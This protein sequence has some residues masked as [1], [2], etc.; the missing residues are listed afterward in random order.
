MRV[1]QV[2]TYI[3][4]DGAFGGPVAVAIAQ[5]VELA[6]RGHEVDLYA[7]WDGVAAVEAPGVTLRLFRTKDRRRGLSLT[8]VTSIR[9]LLDLRRRR[10]YYDVFHLHFG[11][12]AVSMS[13]W[14]VLHRR[15]AKAVLQTHGM[16]V[17]DDRIAVRLV[18]WL[19]VIRAL[20]TARAV[21]A[22][23]E[24]EANGLISIGGALRNLRRIDNGVAFPA[25]P[26]IDRPA[27]PRVVLFLA[28]LHQRK[29]VLQFAEAARLARL[30]GLAAKFRVVGPDE[31]DLPALQEF[32]TRHELRGYLEYGGS[33]GPGGSREEL[34]AAS[35]YV[36]PSYRE[37]YPMTVLE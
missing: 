10:S 23:T 31:G 17:P 19:I 13:T 14:L 18:D 6:R 4:A 27:S 7:A 2:V 12:D 16:V 26:E 37:V 34:A 30:A 5:C 20:R 28:R 15:R 3:S 29:N 22:L 9:L 21:L 25:A 33:V 8:R 35:V 24:Q 1:A 11:R 32:I 36:L